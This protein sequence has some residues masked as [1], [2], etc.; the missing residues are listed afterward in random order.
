MKKKQSPSKG[1]RENQMPKAQRGSHEAKR[2]LDPAVLA[3]R[4]VSNMERTPTP[5]SEVENDKASEQFL[6]PVY[7]PNKFMSRSQS[8]TH[9]ARAMPP[10]SWPANRSQVISKGETK[11]SANFGEVYRTSKVEVALSSLPTVELK[12]SPLKLS[13]EELKTTRR[14]SFLPKIEGNSKTNSGSFQNVV[15]D[16]NLKR[17]PQTSSETIKLPPAK[18]RS[19]NITCTGSTSP[20]LCPLDKNSSPEEIAEIGIVPKPPSVSCTKDRS[21]IRRKAKRRKDEER[22]N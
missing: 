1:S 4:R 16:Y 5:Y 10:A 17:S 20:Q 22:N 14:A 6:G 18:I 9:F 21:N 15:C 13:N 12:K 8:Y 11:P 2:C 7:V 3:L 19:G